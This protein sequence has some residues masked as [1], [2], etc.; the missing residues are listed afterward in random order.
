MRMPSDVYRI[1]KLDSEAVYVRR[2]RL[3]ELKRVDAIIFDCDGVLVD[4]RGSYNR[5]ISKTVAYIYEG[6]TGYIMPESFISDDLV[7]LF[8]ASGG[9]NDDSD[10]TYGILM[11]ILSE[12]PKDMRE[13]IKKHI[14]T[15]EWEPDPF[16]RF[17]SVKQDAKSESKRTRFIETSLELI[18]GRLKEFTELLDG[19]GV[20]SVDRNILA[21]SGKNED[22]IR[23]HNSLK[24]FLSHPSGV[25][26]SIVS[27]VFE[28][29]FCG[30]KL[31]LETYGLE[32]TFHKNS[33]F[34]ENESVIIQPET[35]ARL[36]SVI[37]RGSFGVASGSRL[38]PAL[39]ILRDV[40]AQFEPEASIFLGDVERSEREY[41]EKY[42]RTI[43]LKKPHPFSLLKAAEALDPL[44]SALYV[45]DTLADVFMVRKGRKT[46]SRLFSAGVY[47]HSS[48]K[49]AL[50]R[51]FLESGCDLILP[52]VNELPTALEEIRAK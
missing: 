4:I 22:L 29:F 6:L 26:R 31:F 24:R 33:G 37:G 43:N 16:R 13:E 35:L 44:H 3:R 52:S 49:D 27:R 25:D 42:G 18:I 21:G 28:E 32:P 5:T 34:V 36:T 46:D 8:R 9:F 12:L 40:L 7:F 11:F 51:G 38:Q 41:S 45:G 48:S 39:Y 2:D 47:L 10:I 23:F 17:S 1:L 20:D 50:L 15:D 14:V 19:S 30:S